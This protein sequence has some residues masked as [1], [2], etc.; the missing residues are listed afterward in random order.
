MTASTACAASISSLVP[1]RRLLPP[2][3]HRLLL[4]LPA[5]ATEKDDGGRHRWPHD[6]QGRTERLSADHTTLI[7]LT[8]LLF[9]GLLLTR[10]LWGRVVR[11]IAYPR[12]AHGS[13]QLLP[14]AGIAGAVALARAPAA[15]GG[16]RSDAE[17]KGAHRG[18][19]LYAHG[20]S[21]WLPKTALMAL[22]GGSDPIGAGDSRQSVLV[23]SSICQGSVATNGLQL[24]L[25]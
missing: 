2:R 8:A 13:P 22:D 3:S 7:L 10:N 17:K 14:R 21:A 5:D 25:R 18:P 1:P 23:I 19:A 6:P 15:I 20:S 16:C 11:R 12:P 4:P 9:D 24:D